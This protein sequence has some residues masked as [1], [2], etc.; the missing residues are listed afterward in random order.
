MGFDAAATVLEVEAGEDAPASELRACT[1]DLRMSARVGVVR[2]A[3]RTIISLSL[4]L[5]ALLAA[6]GERTF[7]VAVPAELDADAAAGFGDEVAPAGTVAS[8]ASAPLAPL[9][10][11]VAESGGEV[12]SADE[13]DTCMESRSTTAWRKRRY[14]KGLASQALGREPDVPVAVELATAAAGVESSDSGEIDEADGWLEMDLG[15]VAAS[16]SAR[17]LLLGVAAACPARVDPRERSSVLAANRGEAVSV[18]SSHSGELR[19]LLR[20]TGV[21]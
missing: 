14:L 3:V 19:E 6:E 9:L 21:P 8:A 2:G 18:K 11:D 12:G 16:P 20:W 7:G 13:G 1:S 15:E 5:E 4:M 17:L 10:A